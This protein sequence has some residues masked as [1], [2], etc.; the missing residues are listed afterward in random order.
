MVE[1]CEELE[2]SALPKCYQAIGVCWRLGAAACWQRRAYEIGAVARPNEDAPRP[3]TGLYPVRFAGARVR[4]RVARVE[5]PPADAQMA[6]C[7]CLRGKA[8][9]PVVYRNVGSVRRALF[10]Y[11]QAD[12]C[13]S[14]QQANPRTFQPTTSMRS[15]VPATEAT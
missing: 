5:V 12:A 14:R 2:G 3:R 7:L 4:Y 11:G 1:R 8:V 6:R 10:T 13:Y 9:Q 15:R